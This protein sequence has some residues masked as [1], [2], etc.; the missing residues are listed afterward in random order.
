MT[1]IFHDWTSTSSI[2]YENDEDS[3]IFIADAF[4]GIK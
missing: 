2:I 1:I 3:I 4:K